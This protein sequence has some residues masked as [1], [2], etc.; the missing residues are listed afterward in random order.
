MF[1]Y[2]KFIKEIRCKWYEG[3]GQFFISLF[4]LFIIIAI[5]VTILS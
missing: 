4:F 1:N 5:I 2:N 3:L